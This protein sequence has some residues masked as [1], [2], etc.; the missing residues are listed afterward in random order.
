MNDSPNVPE[1]A[2][3]K[4]PS[5]GRAAGAPNAPNGSN[6]HGTPAGRAAVRSGLADRR[7]PVL[8]RLGAFATGVRRVLFRDPLGTFLFL[9]S[10]ALTVTFF[11]LLGSI[12]PSSNGKE[13]PL[14]TVQNLADK[15]HVASAVLLDHD[16]RVEV[17]TRPSAPA[18]NANGS[19]VTRTVPVLFTKGKHKGK[20]TGQTE[21]TE[22]PSGQIQELWAAY[23]ASGRPDPAAVGGTPP[24]RR[25]GD[26]RTAARQGHAPDHRPVPDPDP[27]PG[28][29]LLAVHEGDGRRRR[30]RDRGLLR[31]HRQ[32]QEEGQGHARQDHLRRRR[33]RRRGGGRAQGDTRL[34]RRS[35]QVPGGRRGRAEGRAAGRASRHRQDAARQGGRRGSRRDVL[36][37][38]GL[39]L[40]RVARRRRRGPRPRPVRQSA[41]DRAG[42]HL[43]RRVRRRGAQARRR[44]RPGQRRARADAEPDPRR[45]GRLLRRRRACRDG[46]HQP[47]GHPRPGAA[48]PWPLRPAGRGRRARR[49]RAPR[50]PAPARR[51]SGR[52]ARTPRWRRLRARRPASAAPSSRT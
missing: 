49:A 4:A 5:P 23:P 13:V 41:Q 45:D 14:S 10:I 7:N 24:R 6:G 16:A 19:A 28:L 48:T 25:H 15:N 22:P 36:L 39:G 50:D 52:S 42:D 3:E 44:H 27:D 20:P 17:T 21:T 38:L 9:A 47:P 30:G 40:R 32:G 34:P 29:P 43:H 46:R 18:L 12:K 8:V 51:A 35:E 26:R 37:D 33:R 11:L 2:G 31:V 1:P